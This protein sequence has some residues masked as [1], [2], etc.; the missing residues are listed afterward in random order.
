MNIFNA[1]CAMSD[2]WYHSKSLLE[3]WINE[4]VL[5][6]PPNTNVYRLGRKL[7]FYHRFLIKWK[8]LI[9]VSW[10]ELYRLRSTTAFLSVSIGLIWMCMYRSISS[11]THLLSASHLV[12]LVGGDRR[13]KKSNNETKT[14]FEQK[15]IWPPSV[16]YGPLID[17]A[18]RFFRI[19]IQ[20]S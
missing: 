13:D 20:Q 7:R 2:D 1:S 9:S 19:L 3:P 16:I 12:L 6:K 15:F 11:R 17:F 10:K 14:R 4:K 5:Q 18:C 8:L